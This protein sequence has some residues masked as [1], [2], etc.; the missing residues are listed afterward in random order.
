MLEKHCA[1]SLSF[2]SPTTDA[3]SVFAVFSFFKIQMFLL[4]LCKMKENVTFFPD[5]FWPQSVLPRM[6]ISKQLDIGKTLL[7]SGQTRC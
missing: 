5:R 1:F 2:L 3:T 7:L 4:A 6:K